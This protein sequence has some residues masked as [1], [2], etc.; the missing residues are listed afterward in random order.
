MRQIN[1]LRGENWVRGPRYIR[2]MIKMES[3]INKHENICLYLM[4]RY[5]FSSLE[6]FRVIERS[7]LYGGGGDAKLNEERGDP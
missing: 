6:V 4:E 1:N 7:R 5:R 2:N 3:V